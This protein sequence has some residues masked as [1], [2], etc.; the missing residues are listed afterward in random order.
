MG[1]QASL[2]YL[3]S[4][5]YFGIKLGL[6]NTAHLLDRLGNPQDALR[7]VHIAGTNGKGS[8]AAALTSILLQAGIPVGLYTSPHLHSFTERVQINGSPVGEDMVAEVIEEIRP[9]ADELGST[10]FEFAT[11]LALCCF[12]RSGVEWAVLEVGMGGRLDATNVVLPELTLITSIDLDHAEHLGASLDAVAAEKA[13]ILKPRVAVVTAHQ[14]AA[15]AQVIR[16]RAEE[17]QAPLYSCGEAFSWQA[18]RE[19][20]DYIGLRQSLT[21]LQPG[22]EGVH[23]LENLSLALAAAELL[24]GRGLDISPANLRSGIA[25]VRWPGRLEWFGNILLDGA[26]N[27]SGAAALAG[28][29]AKQGVADVRWVAG[30]KADKA[31]QEILAPLL[32]GTGRLYACA[33]PVEAAVPP[34]CVV[35]CARAAGVSAEV[36]DSPDEALRRALA[37]T[38]EDGVVLVAGSLFLV[39]AVRQRLLDKGLAPPVSSLSP[40]TGTSL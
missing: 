28:Y 3:Y 19:T 21:G 27:P 31:Y 13:G 18:N 4:L 22:L 33:P 10:F 37:D 7:I 14:P 38:G 35:D 17:L 36:C 12:Q 32:P 39:A 24:R 2:D 15:A 29:L 16:A 20:F 8:T 1:Y 26:H 6:E 30:F 5:Q 34:Q 23:Q 11:A 9:I 40:S 25:V